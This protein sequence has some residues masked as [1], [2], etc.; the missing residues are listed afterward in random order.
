MWTAGK[1][2]AVEERHAIQRLGD[3]FVQLEKLDLPVVKV[4]LMFC[5]SKS[6]SG[7]AESYVILWPI[8]WMQ[9]NSLYLERKYSSLSTSSRPPLWTTD[10]NLLTLLIS[11][12]MPLLG[13]PTGLPVAM[14]IISWTRLV[15]DRDIS[16]AVVGLRFK[17]NSSLSAD[18]SCWVQS[19]LYAVRGKCQVKVVRKTGENV[20]C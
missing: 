1:A 14:V 15:W 9:G 16:V 2:V 12:I 8:N 7:C 17:V 20:V 10:Y 13:L 5:Q 3:A 19:A 11:S 4:C 6:Y 18:L